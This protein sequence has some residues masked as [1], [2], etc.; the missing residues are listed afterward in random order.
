MSR[1]CGWLF[2]V[3]LGAFLMGPASA[4]ERYAVGIQGGVLGYGGISGK[5]ALD[6]KLTLQAVFGGSAG[7]VGATG[8]ALFELHDEEVYRVYGIGELGAGYGN[9]NIGMGV[10]FGAGIEANWQEL[11]EN[12]IPLWWSAEGGIKYVLGNVP[13]PMFEIGIH[14]KIK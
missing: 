7:G 3:V 6:D 8:R 12:V 9:D 5:M 1:V 10:G 13:T 2:G 11:V 4:G 14:Y